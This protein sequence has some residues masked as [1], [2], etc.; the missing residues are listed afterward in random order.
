[1]STEHL[2]SHKWNLLK[3]TYALPCVFEEDHGQVFDSAP[4]ITTHY[5]TAAGRE[6]NVMH[7]LHF[8]AG[9]TIVMVLRLNSRMHDVNKLLLYNYTEFGKKIKDKTEYTALQASV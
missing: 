3:W 1:M 4:I 5:L 2:V 8:C 7:E 9:G 6:E